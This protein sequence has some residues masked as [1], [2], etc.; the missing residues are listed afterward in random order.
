M[1]SVNLMKSS[2]KLKRYATNILSNPN[3]NKNIVSIITNN[4]NLNNYSFQSIKCSHP[5]KEKNNSI[6]YFNE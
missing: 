5:F 3:N 1:T 4:S 2:S 6:Y